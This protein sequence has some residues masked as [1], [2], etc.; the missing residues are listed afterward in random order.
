MDTQQI[1]DVAFAAHQQNDVARAAALY[2]D[3][4]AADPLH[5]QALN[6][7]G[8]IRFAQNRVDEALA[9]F[10]QALDIAPSYAPAHSNIAAAAV[11]ARMPEIALHHAKLA[12]TA[13]PQNIPAL[14]NMSEAF[15][16]L[17]AYDAARSVAQHGLGISPAYPEL[18]LNMGTALGAQGLPNAAAAFYRVAIA[19]NSRCVALAKKNLGQILLAQGNFAEG[20]THYAARFDADKIHPRYLNNIEWDGTPQPGGTLIV[21][22]EQGLGDEILYLSML[23]DLKTAYQGRVIWEMDA[24]L[25]PLVDPAFMDVTFTPRS[26]APLRYFPGATHRIDAGDIGK[27]LRKCAADF[28]PLDRNPYIFSNQFTLKFGKTVG[29]SWAS[30]NTEKGIDK[31]I[32][33][34]EWEPL[35]AELHSRDVN[36]VSLQYGLAA[37]DRRISEPHFDAYRDLVSLA[38]HINACDLVITASNTTAHLAGAMGKPCVVILNDGLGRYWYWGEKESTAFYPSVLIVRRNKRPWA[39]VFDELKRMLDFELNLNANLTWPPT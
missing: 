8:A 16:Q 15:I 28:G 17:K 11:N 9:F 34:A 32:P 35:L 38:A 31:T 14:V 5:F 33:L 2:A 7:L 1:F 24:R 19:A 23:R 4:L 36:L 30:V 26:L 6:N 12:Y 20:W 27:F 3:V 21:A 22:A 37:N 18:L 39:D 13:D 25:I 29:I 10:T